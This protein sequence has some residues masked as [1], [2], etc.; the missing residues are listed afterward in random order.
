MRQASV[1]VC[2]DVTFTL[3]GKMNIHGVY[4]TDIGIPYDPYMG[5]QLVFVFLVETSPDDPYKALELSVEL[6]GGG[7]KLRMP[8]V[9]PGLRPTA[10]DQIR[11]TFRY[12]LL[13]TVP[14][15]HP[16]PIVAKVIHEKGEISAAAPVVVLNVPPNPLASSSAPST[17]S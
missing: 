16:G 11:W 4:T 6:P 14:V 5:S 8:I 17:S 9:V 3:N 1:I 12:P 13:L 2:D 15:L 10:S 7:Q